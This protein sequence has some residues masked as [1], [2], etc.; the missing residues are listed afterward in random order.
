MPAKHFGGP[1]KISFFDGLPDGG[2]ADDVAIRRYR[3]NADDIE[4]EPR[5][6]FLEKI[7][8]PG[9]AFAERP[10]V[11]DANLTQRFRIRDQLV[12]KLFRRRGR[13]FFVE[14]DDEQMRDPEIPDQSDLVLRRGEQMRRGLWAQYFLRMGIECDDDWRAV[15]GMRVAGGRGDD[16]LMAEMHAVEHTDSEKERAA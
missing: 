3:R 12:D 1:G 5:A 8:I 6:E 10:F 4:I 2:A 9:P 13:E 7:E 11:A 15:S 16:R 14:L